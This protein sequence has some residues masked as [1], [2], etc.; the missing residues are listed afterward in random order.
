MS[1][2]HHGQ[3]APYAVGDDDSGGRAHAE[4]EHPY[5]S[6]FQRDRDR[7]L[8]CTAFRRLDYKTQVF[9]P[10]VHDHFRT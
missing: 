5:R 10:H 9:V 6:C 4:R 8:H 2:A 7:V 1:C 3:P